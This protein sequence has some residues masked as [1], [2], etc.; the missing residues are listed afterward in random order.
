M[1]TDS[2]S[3]VPVHGLSTDP[4]ERA[5]FDDWA[6]VFAAAGRH[7]AD[8]DPQTADELRV[9]ETD[10]TKL[11]VRLAALDGS[12][13]CGALNLVMPT[14]DN[15]H[16]AAFDLAVLP[17]RRRRGIGTALLDACES[18]AQGQ[19]RTTLIAETRWSGDDQSVGDVGGEFALRFG[20]TPAQTV[21]RSDFSVTGVDTMAP[22]VAPGYAVETCIGTPPAADRADRAWLARR[23]STDAPLGDLDIGEEEW[24]EKRVADLDARLVAMERGR[25]SAVARHLES[26]RLIAFTEI[27][28]PK[29]SPT[30]AYQEDTLVLT[31]HRGCGLGLVLKLANLG[32]LRAA[33]PAV[34]TIRT[35]NA[36][37]NTHMLAVNTAM[38]FRPSGFV[39]EWQKVV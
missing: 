1:S 35:W 30:L 9:G 24:D 21:L 5:R 34:R 18:A 22:A 16:L 13:V 3:L 27:Q 33:Y 20:Y 39:R 26:G 19:G 6:S 31:E 25:V 10:P 17:E 7:D 8:E 2:L 11:R 12:V 28:V 15:E 32:V 29:D 14:S 23:M 36:V 37:G 4:A 38:G